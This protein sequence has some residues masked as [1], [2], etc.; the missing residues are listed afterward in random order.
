MG[1]PLANYDAVLRAVRRLM[2]KP[3]EGFGLG[4]RKITVST[5]GLVRQMRRLAGE[6]LQI[7]L[8][9][10]LHAPD[11]ETRVRIVPSAGKWKVAEIVGAARH[12]FE[13]TGR[14]V[15]F[16]YVMVRNVNSS[17]EQ[18]RVLGSLLK[19][20]NAKVNLIPLNPV[21]ERSFRPPHPDALY[22]F[23]RELRRA[24]VAATVR[25]ER[26]AEIEAACGQ[27]RR[28]GINPQISPITGIREGPGRRV[29]VAGE[30]RNPRKRRIKKNKEEPRARPRH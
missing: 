20:M 27:L 12:Y 3:P 6:G 14:N 10:S 8:A 16:E 18:A 23:L 13:K 7:N 4:A 30:T 26:G 11:D 28:K 24:G 22:A 5:V 25:E 15:T 17:Q 21:A 1:E 29:V 2:A 9:V 19:G